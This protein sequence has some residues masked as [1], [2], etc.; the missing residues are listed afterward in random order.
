MKSKWYTWSLVGIDIVTIIVSV[1]LGTT[2]T[3]KKMTA[4]T[5]AIMI[6]VMTVGIG[7]IIKGAIGIFKGEKGSKNEDD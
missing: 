7:F 1:I 5:L 2:F 4:L 6:I 3:F